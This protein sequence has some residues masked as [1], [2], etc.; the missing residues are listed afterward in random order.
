MLHEDLDARLAA[1]EARAPVAGEPPRPW[2]ATTRRRRGASPVLLAVGLTLA[3][4]VTAAAVA[5]EGLR[6]QSHPGVQNPGQPLHGASLECLS[7][8]EAERLLLR[9]G[10]R[11]VVWQVE[12][13]TGKTG[14][15]IQ[16]RSA[17]EHGYVVPGAIVE[18][19]LYMVVDQRQGATGTGDCFRMEMP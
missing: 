10:F 5:V 3:L 13:G 19:V 9:K 17:P 15:S 14:T 16:P 6:A 11:D 18:G 2:L 12:S 8:R 4:G 1:L 7:P